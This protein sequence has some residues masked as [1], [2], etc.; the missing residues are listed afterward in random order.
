MK[1]YELELSIYTYLL[2]LIYIHLIYISSIII[3]IRFLCLVLLCFDHSLC[4]KKGQ[5][6]QY[7]IEVIRCHSIQNGPKPSNPCIQLFTCLPSYSDVEWAILWA[8]WPSHKLTHSRPKEAQKV[9]DLDLS[10]EADKFVDGD[11][12]SEPS[13][14]ATHSGSWSNII[15]VSSTGIFKPSVQWYHCAK[16]PDQ[17][18]ELLLCAKLFPASFKNPK[19]AFTFEVLN[20]FWV[21]ALECKTASMNFMS[22]IRQIMDE[23]FPSHVPVSV[24]INRM[25]FHS[26]YAI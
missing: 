22:K 6:M 23:A 15:I 13:G 9:F 4:V 17:F 21:S 5:W 20:H 11:L 1:Y 10:D 25:G 26:Y 8:V 3:I 16:S 12:P 24:P 19:T 2:I 14:S 7:P 18:V